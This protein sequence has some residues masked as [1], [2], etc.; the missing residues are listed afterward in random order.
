MEHTYR[1]SFSQHGI[2]F[3]IESTDLKW[4]EKKEKEY[5][6]KL[7]ASPTPRGKEREPSHAVE[8]PVLPQNLTINE[9][10]KKHIKPRDVKSRTDIAVFFMYY[11]EKILKKDTIKTAD[12]GQCFADIAYPNYSKLNVTDILTKARQKALLNFVNGFWALTITGEDYVVNTLAS[13]K[14]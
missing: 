9:F 14:G 7:H 4:L 1:I 6:A 10:Y 2:S 5:L 11:L 12:I 3:D 8:S 13:K